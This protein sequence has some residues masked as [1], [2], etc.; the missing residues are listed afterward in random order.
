MTRSHLNFFLNV[1]FKNREFYLP[2]FNFILIEKKLNVSKKKLD[3][4]NNF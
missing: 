1:T 2:T 3:V 4:E